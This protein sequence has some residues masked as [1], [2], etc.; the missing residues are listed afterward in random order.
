MF[1]IG[2]IVVV[3][4][5]MKECTGRIFDVNNVVVVVAV[6]GMGMGLAV[7]AV[8]MGNHVDSEVEVVAE[9]AVVEENIQ[10][11]DERR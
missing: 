8:R 6:G 10:V 7:L 9:A 1:D 3:D 2:D 4:V 5:D 11:A